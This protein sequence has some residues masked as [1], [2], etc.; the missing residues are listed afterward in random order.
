M[1]NNGNQVEEAAMPQTTIQYV[2]SR[3]RQLGVTD[4]FGVPGD[5]AFPIND[6]IC[7]DTN[8]R[9]IGSC[10]ELN[11]AYAADGYARVKGLAALNTTYG[12]GELG[13]LSGV[14]GAY[15]EHVPIFHLTGQPTR[16]TQRDRAVV[17]HTLGNGEFDLFYEMTA[18]AVCARTI[19]T[20]ENCIAET[21]RLIAAALY[22]RRPVY[23]ALPSDVANQQAVGGG[24][25]LAEPQSDPASLESAVGAIVD[26]ATRAKTAC[27]LPGIF[28]ARLGLREE[29]LAVVDGSGLPFATMMMDK[30][31]LD[32]AHPNYIGMYAGAWSDENVRAFVEQSDCVLAIGSLASDYNT[33]DFTAKL[34]RSKTINVTHHR[35]R[36]GYAWYENVEMKDVL[37]ALAKGLP[38]R[39]DIRGPNPS[40]S[41]DP[42]GRGDDKITAEAL[43]P[44]WAR[45]FRPDD[46]VISE[47]GTAS[48][49]LSLVRMPKGATLHNQTLWGA[50]GWATPAAFGA[51]LAAPH[52]RTILITG[53]GSHQ[54][55][56]QEVSQ[57]HRVGLKPIIFVLNNSGYLIERLLCKNPEIYY[58][59]LAPWHYQLLPQA[60]GCDGWYASRVTTCG[61]LDAALA[62]AESCGT[63]AYIEVVTDKYV[64]P[65]LA[66]KMHQSTES[67]YKSRASREVDSLIASIPRLAP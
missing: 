14:A 9:F 34:D 60:L 18:P 46:I 42:Q 6:A 20:P 8:L 16:A 41:G 31:V 19:I 36:V 52:R 28:I 66:L 63:G 22:H 2:L 10:N 59:D 29:A 51:A 17:H 50:I 38:K 24:A 65:P 54:M 61:E 35:T 4:F 15:A 1:M 32:E 33:G 39:T 25:P 11:A 64:A 58:N 27:I 57:F 12:P 44:R 56:A 48:L 43:Y 49:G 13:A 45:F 23:M 30:T 5:F 55:T 62:E 67:L 47:L 40:S 7:E 53:E 21:E 26:A 37:T 3:L